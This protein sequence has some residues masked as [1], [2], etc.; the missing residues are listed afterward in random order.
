MR[1]WRE[2]VPR[3]YSLTPVS[4]Q[5]SCVRELIILCD[6]ALR[7]IRQKDVKMLAF[8]YSIVNSCVCVHS[9][10]RTRYKSLLREAFDLGHIK[11]LR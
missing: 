7:T 3:I 9:C 4:A 5:L 8:A 2:N 10:T 11:R 1:C 6:V